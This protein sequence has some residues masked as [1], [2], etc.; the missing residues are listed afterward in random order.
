MSLKVAFVHY[1]LRPGG[2][3]RVIDNAVRSLAAADVQAVTLTGEEPAGDWIHPTEV[4]SGLGYAAASTGT[5]AEGASLATDMRAAARRSLGTDPDVWHIHNHSLGKNVAFPRAV[6]HLAELGHRL[7]L[8]LHDF[9]EDGR[10]VNYQNLLASAPADEFDRTAYPSGDQVHYAALNRRDH[11][12]LKRAGVP[13]TRL[14]LLSNPVH[15]AEALNETADPT[16]GRIEDLTLY[17]ARGIRRKNLGEFVLWS[18]RAEAGAGYAI[19]LRPA[20]PLEQ[21]QYE[22]WAGFAGRAGL[23]VIFSAGE[24]APFGQ[25]MAKAARLIT[26]SVAEG[27]GLAFLEP[28]LAGRPLVGRDLPEITADFTDA[29]VN[30]D[31]LYPRLTVPLELVD[32]PELHRRVDAWMRGAYHAYRR[33]LPGGAVAAAVA[34]HGSKDRIDFGF[35]DEAL[36]M[37]VIER[38]RQSPALRD[39]IFAG[40][41]PMGVS[42]ETVVANAAIVA[43]RFNLAD[44]GRRLKAIYETL[45][46]S[47]STRVGALNAGQIL[48]EF[49]SPERF[50]LLRS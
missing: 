33:E 4:V 14:H 20:N 50:C 48:T 32:E 8:H 47:S 16:M 7:L 13:E 45:A 11:D 27:F 25:W 35:L 30:L 29:G 12:V 31:A 22:A 46:A 1:H 37:S 44:Y 18:T 3:T 38:A 49:L 10:P 21:P 19:T 17:P 42:L 2:V 24:R 15:A 34:S 43:S 26:T 5:S 40:V 28:W 36:Q 9:A 23:P 39:E 41:E 6:R